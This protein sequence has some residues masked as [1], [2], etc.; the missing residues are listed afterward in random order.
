ME[1]LVVDAEGKLT[2]PPHILEKRGLHPGDELT[3]VE[4]D[5]GLLVYQHGLD[6]L[7]ARWWSGL[8]E[9][10][11][12]QARAEA[13]RYESL[14]EE[15]RDRIW[16]EGAESIEEDAEGDEVDLPAK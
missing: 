5:E 2:I 11:R 8:S 6:P 12:R 16:N 3:L 15:E 7:T 10:E 13:E 1:K 9:D 4:A 14:S